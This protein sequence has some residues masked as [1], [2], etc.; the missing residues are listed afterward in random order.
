MNYPIIWDKQ[1]FKNQWVCFRKKFVWNDKTATL[2]AAVD[3]KYVLYVNGEMVVFDGGLNRG[4]DRNSGY[5]DEVDIASYLQSGE[6]TLAFLVWYWGNEGRCNFDSGVPGLSFVVLGD[7]EPVCSSSD[8]VKCCTHP[9]YGQS[10]P[11]LPSYLYG[12]DNITYFF[13]D[14]SYLIT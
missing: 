3:S 1:S 6:N 4:P 9:C 2:L 7:D 8:D 10:V 14:F 12:G 5:Y 13:H 11:P